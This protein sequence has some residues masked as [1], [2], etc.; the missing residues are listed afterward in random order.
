MNGSI[1]LKHQV[2]QI[3]PLFKHFKNADCKTGYQTGQVLAG[4]ILFR[5]EALDMIE[6]VNKIAIAD[7]NGDDATILGSDFYLIT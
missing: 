5:G 2:V 4:P 3:Y 1:I 6:V 7:Y